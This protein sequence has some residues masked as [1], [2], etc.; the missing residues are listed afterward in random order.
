MDSLRGNDGIPPCRPWTDDFVNALVP[1]PQRSGRT[2]MTGGAS[3]FFSR[4]RPMLFMTSETRPSASASGPGAPRSCRTDPAPSRQERLLPGTV[5]SSRATAFFSSSFPAAGIQ[6]FP[7]TTLK[8]A[9]YSWR[10]EEGFAGLSP[11]IG[12][13][14]IFSGR[15]RRPCERTPSGSRSP[16]SLAHQA[17][18]SS[19]CCGPGP[20]PGSSVPRIQKASVHRVTSQGHP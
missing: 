7:G 2:A 8:R 5:S 17:V 6:V 4:C 3:S 12:D 16:G 18:T 9:R 14:R 19:N 20:G 1:L 10:D 13:V 11:E 15:V